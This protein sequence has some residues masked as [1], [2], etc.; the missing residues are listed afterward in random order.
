MISITGL[1]TNVDEL[2][3]QDFEKLELERLQSQT[4]TFKKHLKI[5]THGEESKA[6][7]DF[8]RDENENRSA[9]ESDNEDE[10]N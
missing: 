2:I 10:K 1:F 8:R 9:S 5:T 6:S 4:M 7:E 3:G